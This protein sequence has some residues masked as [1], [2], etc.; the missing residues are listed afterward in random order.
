MRLALSQSTDFIQGTL[1]LYQIS[2]DQSIDAMLLLEETACTAWDTLLSFQ[3]G[4]YNEAPSLVADCLKNLDGPPKHLWTHTSLALLLGAVWL[5]YKEVSVLPHYPFIIATSRNGLFKVSSFP[6]PP[7]WSSTSKDTQEKQQWSLWSSSVRQDPSALM[8]LC[9][10]CMLS[11]SVSW[12]WVLPIHGRLE[13]EWPQTALLIQGALPKHS[14]WVW[15][16]K[17]RDIFSSW[18]TLLAPQLTW[19][20]P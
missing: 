15:C 3:V 10:W 17:R 5:L 8:S 19:T 1:G 14:V 9:S 18:I 20:S 11:K 12:A 2:W 16:M 6:A 7:H 4:S 13:E